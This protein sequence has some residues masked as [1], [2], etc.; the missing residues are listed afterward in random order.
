MLDV[1]KCHAGRARWDI[2]LVAGL[3]SVATVI[4]LAAVGL[5]PSTLVHWMVATALHAMAF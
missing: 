3:G 1:L 4:G 5:S 2:G